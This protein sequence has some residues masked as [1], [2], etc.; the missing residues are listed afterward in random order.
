MKF[1]IK[2]MLCMVALNSILFSI[3]S[4]VLIATAFQNSLAREKKSAKNSYRMII[5][6]LEMVNET[7]AWSDYSNITD[8]LDSL[9]DENSSAWSALVLDNKDERIY[10]QGEKKVPFANLQKQVSQKKNV[11]TMLDRKKEQQ[12]VQLSGIFLFGDEKLYLS[13]AYDITDLYL[14]R[15]R[16][17][18]IFYYTFGLMIV[19][20]SAVSYILSYFLTKPLS[21]LSKASQE[22]ASGNYVFRSGISSRDEIGVVSRDF[23]IMADQVQKNIMDMEDSLVR[24]NKFLEN[25]THELKTPMTSIIGYADLLRRQS[26]SE[27]EQI[28][29]MQYI[30]QEGKRLERLSFKLLDIFVTQQQKA[31][32]ENVAP[33]D[34][35][36]NI[37]AHLSDSYT[38]KKITFQTELES[39]VCMLDEDLFRSLIE[40]LI[41]NARKAFDEGGFIQIYGY[42]KER[43]Y[44]ISIIDNGRGIPEESL[45]HLSEAFYR[46]DKS[47][48]RVLGGA[49]LGLALCKEIVS[50]HNGEMLFQSELG[51]GTTVT[52]F[53]RGGSNE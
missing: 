3:G 53:L 48:A 35:V 11:F 8:A 44:E 10:I 14:N 7:D 23:D 39:G 12:Y 26:L 17:E 51:K 52:V 30:Y 15:Q 13:V 45:R 43:G 37:V 33:A 2:L 38:E 22:F 25:F 1:R 50:I 6:T 9:Y 49:G 29:A 42:P 16:Q 28:D 36:N 19:I 46:V 41:D 24:Q 32:F 5:T 31:E 40:N 4:S 27:Q 47:R 21:R 34:I 20:S 18:N